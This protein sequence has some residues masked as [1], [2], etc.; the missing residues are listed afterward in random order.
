MTLTNDD[1]EHLRQ[2]LTH[3][4]YQVLQAIA[5][6]YIETIQEVAIATSQIE[7][8]THQEKI[9]AHWSMV[10]SSK[11]FRAA[12]EAGVRYEIGLLTAAQQPLQDKEANERLRRIWDTLGMLEPMPE[13]FH[14][15]A[16]R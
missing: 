10:T 15:E 12:L 7:P 3:P 4:G 14:H 9:A 1:R 16:Q 8:M 13:D 5:D 11:A 2:F 6:S